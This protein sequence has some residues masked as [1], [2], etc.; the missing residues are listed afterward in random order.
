[1]G[2]WTGT[3]DASKLYAV[4]ES[5]HDKT[6]VRYCTVSRYTTVYLTFE[7]EDEFSGSVVYRL[8]LAGDCNDRSTC[9]SSW[10]IK[11]TRR[12]PAP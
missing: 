2:P 7:S 9:T 10:G 6:L 11:G 5:A 3:W 4:G 1:M 8:R 12:L